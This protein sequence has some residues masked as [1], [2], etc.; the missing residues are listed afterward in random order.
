M[1]PK[2]SD[3]VEQHEMFDTIRKRVTA[4]LKENGRKTMS[5]PIDAIVAIDTCRILAGHGQPSDEDLRRLWAALNE[6]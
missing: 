5:Y 2:L 4:R 1:K 3:I 6:V